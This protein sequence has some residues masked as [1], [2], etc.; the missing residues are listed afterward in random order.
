MRITEYAAGRMITIADA[1]AHRYPAV[2]ESLGGARITLK[3]AE[4]LVD[5]VDQLMPELRAAVAVKAL[6]LA[7][8]EPVGTF[9]RACTP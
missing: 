1:L 2:L 5:P 9:R 3:H 8:A 4:I 7:E 6:V